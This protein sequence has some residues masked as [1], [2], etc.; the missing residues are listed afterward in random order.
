MILYLKHLWHY[1]KAVKNNKGFY[2][3]YRDKQNELSINLDR[4][5]IN[6][7]K[8]T[9]AGKN[10]KV[11][12]EDGCIL[13]GVWFFLGGNNNSIHIGSH[14][15]CNSDKRRLNLFS[16]AHGTSLKIGTRCLFAS[17][18]EIQTTDHHKIL[19]DG[20]QS[21]YSKDVNIGNHCWVAAHT[22][23]LKGVTIADNNIIGACSLVVKNCNKSNCILAGHPASIV[24]RNVNWDY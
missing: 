18:I 9:F 6:Q 14:T 7:C 21:N 10:N 12:I 24:K 5:Q 3:A 2:S 16:V 4:S 19:V 22:T 15:Y 20:K 8:F 17:D 1:I 13:N 23:I 11:I